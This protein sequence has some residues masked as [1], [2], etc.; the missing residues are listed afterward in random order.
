M[1]TTTRAAARRQRSKG[2]PLSAYAAENKRRQAE[3]EP[4]FRLRIEA[5]IAELGGPGK[6]QDAT[7]IKS[8]TLQKIR[9]GGSRLALFAVFCEVTGLNPIWLLLGGASQPRYVPRVGMIIDAEV[10]QMGTRGRS[11]DRRTDEIPRDSSNRKAR[12]KK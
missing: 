2:P 11:A 5:A 6:V 3:W 4:A 7:H 1:T 8:Q 12:S 10:A 9:K